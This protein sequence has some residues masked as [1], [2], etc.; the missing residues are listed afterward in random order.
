MYVKTHNVA[1]QQYPYSEEELRKDYSQTSFPDTIS[2]ALLASYEVFPVKLVAAPAVDHTKNVVEGIP[3][4]QGQGWVQTWVVTNAT[5]EE[6]QERTLQKKA[7]VR[8]QRD[9]LLTKSDCTQ[10]LDFKGPSEAWRPYRQALRD[11]TS[12]SGFP[13]SV[14]W[15]V[16]PV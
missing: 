15:P 10:M 9:L 5:Q 16:P 11:L 14:S 3:C 4:E 12:Q 13:W 6:I 8:A 7:D 2:A 1:V